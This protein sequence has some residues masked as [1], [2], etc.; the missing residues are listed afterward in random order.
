MF[1]G[2]GELRV[3]EL[4]DGTRNGQARLLLALVQGVDLVV[5]WSPPPPSPSP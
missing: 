2:L 5:N 1:R 3:E 4:L